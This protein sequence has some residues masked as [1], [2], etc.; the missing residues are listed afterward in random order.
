[1]FGLACTF[2]PSQH[3]LM[4]LE[5]L[6]W[7]KRQTTD[8]ELKDKLFAYYH[9]REHTY[10]IGLWVT[11]PRRLFVDLINM[12]GSPQNFSKSHATSFQQ[13][14]FSPLSAGQMKRELR[15][16]YSDHLHHINDISGSRADRELR[17]S[18]STTKVA[19]SRR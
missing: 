7:C 8:P 5:Q 2:N 6:R 13:N 4:D 11:E 19:M 17:Q 14:M 16:E 9:L 12:G 3:K 1:M 15:K 10:I 18:S